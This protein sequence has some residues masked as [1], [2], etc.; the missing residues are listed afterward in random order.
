MT[1]RLNAQR[2]RERK[3]CLKVKKNNH[4]DRFYS[5][6]FLLDCSMGSRQSSAKN[7]SVDDWTFGTGENAV[8]LDAVVEEG[9]KIPAKYFGGNAIQKDETMHQMQND[10]LSFDD[11][12]KN[13]FR[14]KKNKRSKQDQEQEPTADEYYYY[15][16][17]QQSEE[18]PQT[19]DSVQN[20]NYLSPVFVQENGQSSSTPLIDEL[21][22]SEERIANKP[23]WRCTNCTVEN[24]ITERVCRRC[25]Q[26]ETKL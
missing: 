5:A 14:R 21:R 4:F 2:E 13:L 11:T 12:L 25:G 24:K 9:K 7:W 23:I 1:L 16:E 26:C 19:T 6:V 8:S 22:E 3:L 20:Q 15:D 17:Q 10:L 18:F